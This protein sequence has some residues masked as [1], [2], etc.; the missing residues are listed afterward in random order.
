MP[1]PRKYPLEY[2]T[3]ASSG[4][5]V[6]AGFDKPRRVHTGR[7]PEKPNPGLRHAAQRRAVG[8]KTGVPAGPDAVAR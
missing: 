2:V 6:V 3:G 4:D 1:A 5:G 7:H 8:G